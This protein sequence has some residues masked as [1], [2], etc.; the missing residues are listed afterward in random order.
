[1]LELEN[2]RL[3][4]RLFENQNDNAK[5][6]LLEDPDIEKKIIVEGNADVN[7]HTN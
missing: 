5:D 1:M 7:I 3:A 6:N 4:A 2:L